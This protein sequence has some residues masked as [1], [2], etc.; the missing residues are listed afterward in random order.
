MK[1]EATKLLSTS[2]SILLPMWTKLNNSRCFR[3]SD[4]Y[5]IIFLSLILSSQLVPHFLALLLLVIVEQRKGWFIVAYKATKSPYFD[6]F[7]F[8]SI[9]SFYQF[10][11]KWPLFKVA[12]PKVSIIKYFRKYFLGLSSLGIWSL[13]P[14]CM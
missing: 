12:E 10:L 3:A 2:F 14:L 8:F 4:R 9:W 5:K 6:S 1:W 13:L 11:V 7:I